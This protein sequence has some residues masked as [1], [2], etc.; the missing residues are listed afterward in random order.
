MI[1]NGKITLQGGLELINGQGFEIYPNGTPRATK[2][3]LPK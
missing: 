2:R 3:C 1:P